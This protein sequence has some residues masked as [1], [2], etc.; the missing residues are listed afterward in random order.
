M[1]SP[2]YSVNQRFPSDPAVMPQAPGVVVGMSYSVMTPAVV[3][4]P[5]L[6]PNH[7]ANQTLPS[8]PEAMLNG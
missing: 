4:R 1:L 2:R 3:M 7:S 8:G 5:I 6:S